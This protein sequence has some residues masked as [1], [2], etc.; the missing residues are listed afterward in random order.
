[1][2]NIARQRK[3]QIG[4]QAAGWGTIAA[5]TV[6]LSGIDPES[7]SIPHSMVTELVAAARGLIGPGRDDIEIAHRVEGVGLGGHVIYE[8]IP[9]FLSFLDEVTPAGAG[10]T[11]YTFTA[12]TTAQVVPHP[13]TL[14]MGVG[15]LVF[16]VCAACASE[17]TFEWD[18]GQALTFSMGIM[19]RNVE[20]DAFAAL[21]E[22]AAADLTYALASH[23]TVYIDAIDGT[24]GATAFSECLSG[25]ITVSC[26]RQ[27]NEPVGS[28]Y[29]SGV[30]DS[31]SW[32]FTGTLVLEE[33]ATSAGYADAIAAGAEAR[34]LRIDF[35]DGGAGAD[36]RAL[37]FNMAAKINVTDMMT[38]DNGMSTV[39]LAFSSIE[40]WGGEIDGIGNIVATN[41][42]AAL[43]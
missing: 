11:T 17:M 36:N 10:P 23:C 35:D 7:I 39:E 37:Q 12:P 6:Q 5:P 26:N 43:Y 34:L 27:Y 9:F 25:S 31:P 22:T 42:D 21:S 14:V 2:T 40:E 1:M 24:L 29:P 4:D 18:A 8:Q 28:L 20:P 41:D 32:D 3:V 15:D 30:Y 16:G 33:T 19:G 13:Q 38:D